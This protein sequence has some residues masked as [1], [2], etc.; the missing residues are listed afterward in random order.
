MKVPVISIGD[1][2]LF[3]ETKSFSGLASLTY[4]GL[5]VEAYYTRI[6]N[7]DANNDF[8]DEEVEIE[9]PNEIDSED[10]EEIEQEIKNKIR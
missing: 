10:W 4:K 2:E 9:K 1:E 7:Y 8:Q 5:R 6:I 3:S